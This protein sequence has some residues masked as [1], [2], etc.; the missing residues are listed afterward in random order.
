MRKTAWLPCLSFLVTFFCINA[1]LSERQEFKADYE[2]L[3]GQPVPGHPEITFQTLC[4]ENYPRIIQ[5]SA[6]EAAELGE[7]KAVV[8]LGAAWCP[9]C[10]NAVPC[11]MSAAETEGLSIIYYVDMSDERDLCEM[12]NGEKIRVIEGTPGYWA[13]LEKLETFLPDYTQSL[14]D[15]TTVKMGEKRIYLPTLAYL[16]NGKYISIMQPLCKRTE[17]QTEYDPLSDMQRTDLTD[18]IIKWLQKN[19]SA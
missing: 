1:A 4:I 14:P 19:G 16:Q 11:L 15:G 2:A 10:R 18:Q 17:E 6:W 13:L 9:W 3:N 5:L 7:N 12:M 8:Y